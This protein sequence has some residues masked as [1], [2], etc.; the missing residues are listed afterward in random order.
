MRKLRPDST[1][2]NLPPYLKDE[3]DEMLLTGQPYRAIQERLVEDGIKL[4]ITS[5]SE[6]Y[7]SQIYPA[8]LARQNR[9]VEALKKISLDGMDEATMQALRERLFELAMMPGGD[10]QSL[11]IIA[12]ILKDADKVRQDEAR[13]KMEQ[14]KW[15]MTAAQAL[16][17]KATSPEVQAIVGSHETNDSK[18]AKLRTLL[19]G[20]RKTITPEFVDAPSF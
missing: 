17:D 3:V 11:K 10:V 6:Y 18:L 1:I 20:Q 5:I 8:K 9:T 4:S 13:L 19:F 14:E 15:Q 7:K 16:L 2:G 12:G